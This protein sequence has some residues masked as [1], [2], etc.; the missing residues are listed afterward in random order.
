M[1]RL[2]LAGTGA[3]SLMASAAMAQM[4]QTTTTTVT[5]SPAVPTIVS[6]TASVG[7]SVT[8]DGVMT[9]SNTSVARDSTGKTTETTNSSTSYPL[10]SMITTTRKVVDVKDGVATET[11]TTRN[12]YPSPNA[13]IPPQVTTTVRTYK[14][15]E[16]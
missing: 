1:T 15:G 7:Q 3:L 5:P 9:L 4:M 8:P 6:S 14:V 12:A 10:S 13:T 2:L 16:D 11:V